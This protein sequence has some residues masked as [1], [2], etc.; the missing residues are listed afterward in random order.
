[1]NSETNR[2]KDRHGLAKMLGA[3]LPLPRGE[4]RGEGEVTA[5]F[6]MDRLN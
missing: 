1:M 2:L 5:R 6:H 4:G 3:F